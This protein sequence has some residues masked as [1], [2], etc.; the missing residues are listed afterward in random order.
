[1]HFHL[2]AD[3]Q[4]L[5]LRFLEIGVDIELARRHQRHQPL[6]RRNEIAFLH[7]AIADNPVIGRLQNGKGQVAGRFVALQFQR[8][9]LAFGFLALRFKN[10][11]VGFCRLDRRIAADKVGLGLIERNRGAVE[12]GGRADRLGGKLGLALER[13]LGTA[14]RCLQCNLGG[15][16]LGKG[17]LRTFDLCVDAGQRQLA[18]FDGGIGLIKRVLVI[19]IVERRQHIAGLDLLVGGDIHFRNESRDL[20]GNRGNI[21]FDIG[22][23]RRHHEPARRP[24]LIS[25]PAATGEQRQHDDRQDKAALAL[26]CGCVGLGFGRWR[27]NRCRRFLGSRRR[28]VARRVIGI[29][30]FVFYGAQRAGILGGRHCRN[31]L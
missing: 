12:I 27:C 10:G 1:M 31:H 28:V 7:R 3:L 13:D 25:I 26:L 16:R 29:H 14:D 18:G 23:V 30:I 8:P 4:M 17:C 20:W 15:L 2:G 5:D 21:A 9:D 22:I 11:D 24:P 19:A 6:S